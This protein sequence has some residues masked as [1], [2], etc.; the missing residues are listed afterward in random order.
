M[1]QNFRALL[2]LKGLSNG[3]QESRSMNN[4]SIHTDRI[5]TRRP[6][7]KAETGKLYAAGL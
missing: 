3:K 2:F 5:S 4:P 1:F 7:K 6:I